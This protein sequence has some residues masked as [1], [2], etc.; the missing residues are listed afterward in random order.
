[1]NGIY[2]NLLEI[3][4]SSYHVNIKRAMVPLLA[5]ASRPLEDKLRI[6]YRTRPDASGTPH[7]EA[8]LQQLLRKAPDRLIVAVLNRFED[9]AVVV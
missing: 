6:G 1:M 5:T 2:L 4:Q 8:R 9:G 3:C 7:P